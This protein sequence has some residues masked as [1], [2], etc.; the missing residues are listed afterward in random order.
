MKTKSEEDRAHNDLIST[1]FFGVEG[2]QTVTD[3]LR[4]KITWKEGKAKGNGFFCG[5]AV[6]K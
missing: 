3:V 2:F 6:H 5:V 1:E 4:V